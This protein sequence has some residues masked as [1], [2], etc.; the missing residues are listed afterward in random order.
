MDKASRKRLKAM[1]RDQERKAALA[2]LPLPI[3]ELEAMFAM[4]DIALEDQACDHTRR[5]TQAWLERR[6]HDVARVFAWLD[7]QGGYCDCEVQNAADNVEEA[8]KAPRTS[9]ANPSLDG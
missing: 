3:A 4:L 5:I 7:E 1:V 6:G 8:K 9:S 2:A